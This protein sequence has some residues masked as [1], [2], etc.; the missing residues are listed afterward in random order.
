MDIRDVDHA[1]H[2]IRQMI[3]IARRSTDGLK[4]S[5]DLAYLLMPGWEAETLRFSLGDIL[6]KVDA[7]KD[8]LA[9]EQPVAAAPNAGMGGQRPDTTVKTENDWRDALFGIEGPCAKPSLWPRSQMRWSRK[10]TGV[11]T[12]I[13]S[14]GSLSR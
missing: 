6:N 14:T 7:L 11:T 9:T 4:A 5:N 3:I 1:L 13:T 10:T 8:D 12:K 2:E